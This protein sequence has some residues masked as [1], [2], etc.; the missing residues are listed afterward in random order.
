MIVKYQKLHGLAGYDRFEDILYLSDELNTE[1][2]IE[3]NLS[4]GYFASKNLY[5]ILLHELAHK[6]HWDRV[7]RLYNRNKKRYNSLEEAKKDLDSPI[8]Q[9]V[10]QQH[11][12]DYFYLTNVSENA[13]LAY[14]YNQN[15]NELVAEVIVIGDDIFD[16]ELLKKVRGVLKWK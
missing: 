3:K 5:D 1:K 12:L 7:K 9:Y 16:K 13:N 6:R 15:I 10:K 14:V 4:S 2:N 11:S 8:I